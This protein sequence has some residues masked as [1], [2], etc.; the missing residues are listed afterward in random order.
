MRA[1]GLLGAKLDPTHPALFTNV[2]ADRAEE[3]DAEAS[4][5]RLTRYSRSRQRGWQ[6]A[7]NQSPRADDERGRTL[8]D[9]KKPRRES[10]GF[11]AEC[12]ALYKRKIEEDEEGRT[13]IIRGFSRKASRS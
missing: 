4:L 2:V 10:G 6:L 7:Q 3:F 5:V 9:K 11:N 1:P 13:C 8:A 12:T